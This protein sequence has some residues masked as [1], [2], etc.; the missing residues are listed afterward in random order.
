MCGKFF[1]GNDGVGIHLIDGHVFRIFFAV[2]IVEHKNKENILEISF[3]T[4]PFRKDAEEGGMESI[5]LYC[6]CLF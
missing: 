5:G 3:S 4:H 2:G 6:F 1:F